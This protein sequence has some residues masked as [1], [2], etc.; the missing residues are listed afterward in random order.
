MRA[1]LLLL[2][3]ALSALILGAHFLRRGHLPAT[4]ACLA[5]L[6]LL[7][8]RRPWAARVAQAALA[9]GAIEWLATLAG[10]VSARRAAG[11]P[12]AR[13]AVI[14]GAV[15]TLA[16]AGALLFETRAL[17]RRFGRAADGPRG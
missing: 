4:A 13:M 17:R 1:V 2:P 10:L 6:A 15:A 11:E 16:L 9:L 12:W 3:A 5:L 7:P 14:L 8:L